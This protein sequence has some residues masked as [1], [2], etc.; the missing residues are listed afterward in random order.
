[1]MMAGGFIYFIRFLCKMCFYGGNYIYKIVTVAA[2]QNH[3]TGNAA[4]NIHGGLDQLSLSS[5]IS[6]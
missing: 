4:D 1:V 2:S 6:L 5:Q 3:R